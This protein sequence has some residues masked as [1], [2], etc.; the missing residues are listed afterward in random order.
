VHEIVDRSRDCKR[1]VFLS[2]DYRVRPFD[3]LQWCLERRRPGL[4]G[5]GERWDVLHYCRTRVGLETALSR[6]RCEGIVL[7]PALLAAFP[8]FFPE[9][10]HT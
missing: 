2:P 7:D 4:K 1:S 9:E 6:L 8:A 10:P 5:G 3:H